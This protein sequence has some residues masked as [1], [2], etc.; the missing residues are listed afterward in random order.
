MVTVAMMKHQGQSN[1]G[2]KGLLSFHFHISASWTDV[3][4]ATQTM[5]EAGGLQELMQR[6][7]RS[8]V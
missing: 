7:R 5:Q 6:L 4:T 3:M 8:A 2:G 1:L